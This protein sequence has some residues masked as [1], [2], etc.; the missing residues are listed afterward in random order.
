MFVSKSFKSAISQQVPQQYCTLSLVPVWSHPHLTRDEAH[1]SRRSAGSLP[2]HCPPSLLLQWAWGDIPRCKPSQHA[3]EWAQMWGRCR[4]D[5]QQAHSTTFD[6]ELTLPPQ[7]RRC[8]AS[9]CGS[10][11]Y[12]KDRQKC[13][14]HRRLW[15]LQWVRFDIFWYI[16]FKDM[17]VSEIWRNFKCKKLVN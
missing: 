8:L 17:N 11:V 9:C 3:G 15:F 5:P 13:K 2:P 1:Q 4:H 16:I 14:K 6:A 10:E 12:T 7:L